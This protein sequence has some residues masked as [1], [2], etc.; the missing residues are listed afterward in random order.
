M[1]MLEQMQAQQMQQRSVARSRSLSELEREVVALEQRERWTAH[2]YEE[3]RATLS[4]CPER[5]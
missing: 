4:G 5:P 3:L 2:A 1:Q